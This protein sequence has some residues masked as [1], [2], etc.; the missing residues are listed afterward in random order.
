MTEYVIHKEL[1]TGSYGRTYMAMANGRAYAVK[2]MDKED[3]DTEYTVMRKLRG[4]CHHHFLCPVE[5]LYARG[6][7]YLVS[8]Y[9]PGTSLDYYYR[10]AGKALVRRVF[11]ERFCVQLLD[12]LAAVHGMHVAHRDIKAENIM[13]SPD[14][15]QFTLIDFGIATSQACKDVYGTALFVA[16]AVYKLHASGDTVPMSVLY[17]S[18]MFALGVVLYELLSGGKYPFKLL[19]SGYTSATPYTS[20]KSPPYDIS[21]AKKLRS[22]HAT[23]W[24]GDLFDTLVYKPVSAETLHNHL[25][26]HSYAALRGFAA[27]RRKSSPR[28]SPK[29]RKN[30]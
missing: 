2:E 4:Q 13:V 7:A 21:V 28:R 16:P 29:R 9:L 25:S 23:V 17:A 12:A 10:R 14:G 19:T 6:R 15:M 22:K 18:D 1:G 8:D 30:T 3:A 26:T 27:R 24:M 20:E 5:L 11:V